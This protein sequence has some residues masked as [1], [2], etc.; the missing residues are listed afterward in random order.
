MS[1]SFF[2]LALRLG[3]FLL[4]AGT[5][6]GLC[7]QALKLQLLALPAQIK[8]GEWTKIQVRVSDEAGKPVPNVLLTLEA[9]GGLFAGAGK[10]NAEGKTDYQGVF[11]TEWSC[12]PCMAEHSIEVNARRAGFLG[13]TEQLL[14]VVEKER[15]SGQLTIDPWIQP[16][17]VVPGQTASLTLLLRRNGRPEAGAF[18]EVSSGG[19]TFTGPSADP[20]LPT[21]AHGLT[22]TLGRFQ[23]DWRCENCARNYLFHIRA[24]AEGHEPLRSQITLPII[25][26]AK[27]QPQDDQGAVEG[28]LI[29]CDPCGFFQVHASS[30]VPQKEQRSVSVSAD[31]HYRISLPSGIYLMEAVP[32][33]REA[34]EEPVAVPWRIKVNVSSNMTTTVNF[35]C[36]E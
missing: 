19:G 2:R 25:E 16:E 22:D 5:A 36:A 3:S 9:D 31:C 34:G 1:L 32:V 29:S 13:A 7:A 17:E 6:S 28:Q 33:H 4:L 21:Y 24:S 23:T 15:L 35:Q 27:E 20:E 10:G 18:V 26:S 11:R 8:P 14:I 12:E 30:V